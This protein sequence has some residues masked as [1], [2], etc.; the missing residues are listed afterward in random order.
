MRPKAGLVSGGADFKE[1][2]V[3]ALIIA[4]GDVGDRDRIGEGGQGKRARAHD[5]TGH[6][7]QR[8][9]GFLHFGPHIL[10]VVLY[11]RL[12]GSVNTLEE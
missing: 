12:A 10:L 4:A 1:G 3:R 2:T 5:R 11:E 8:R 6:H 7:T 9:E